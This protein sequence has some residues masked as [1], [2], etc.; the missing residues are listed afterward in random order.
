MNPVRAR[1][2]MTSPLPTLPRRRMLALLGAFAAAPALADGALSDDAATWRALSRLGYGPTPALIEQV[3]QAGGARAWALA[4]IDAAFA[5]SAQ[6]VQYGGVSS[7]FNAPLPE[8]FE[9]YRDEREQRREIR[10]AKADDAN[11]NAKSPQEMQAPDAPPRYSVQVARAA[12]EWRLLACSRPDLEH[13][14]LARMTEFWFNHLNVSADKG[15]VRPFVGHYAVHAIRAHA[16]GR[17]DELLLASARHPAMLAYLDQAQSVAE[18]TLQGER[19]RG[20]NENYAR[21][22]M[23]LHTLGVGGGY[24][25]TDVRELA[26]VLTGWTVGR[27]QADGFRFAPRL[28]DS[29]M[30][31]VLG[32]RFGGDAR[33]GRSEGES[34]GVAAIRMLSQQPAT[35]RRVALRLAQWFVADEPPPALIEQLARQFQSSGGDT[36]AV[37]RTLVQSDAFWEPANRLFKTPVDFACSA[38]AA[39]GGPQN[40]RELRQTLASLQTAGQGVLRWHTPDGYKTSRATWLAPEALTRRADYAL[41]L[42][43]RAPEVGYLARFAKADTR[44]RIEAQPVAL[45]AGLLL[46]SPDFMAK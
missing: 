22:L 27:E 12:A 44:A 15:S 6:P 9:R 36:R 41:L 33:A 42:A 35:A 39:A 46:A 26:R 4:A 21:E 5:A 38:L 30:K 19:R 17:F 32:Q 8:I 1:Q 29:G 24:T 25:Q 7:D 28:H 45:R 16:L 14:L 34:E 40:E 10:Q 18:G 31:T 13:P 3:R 23:E 20:L 11:A 37:L 43:R 2:P